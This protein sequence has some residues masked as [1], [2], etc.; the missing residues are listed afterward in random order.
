MT[1]PKYISLTALF[2]LLLVLMKTL[3]QMQKYVTEMSVTRLKFNVL[4]KLSQVLKKT[5]LS[6]V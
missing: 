3:V 1:K 6:S 5:L 2:D 4:L